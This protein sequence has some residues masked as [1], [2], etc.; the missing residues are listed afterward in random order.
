MDYGSLQPES[1]LN[2]RIIAKQ[3][4][5]LTGRVIRPISML[6]SRD[7]DIKKLDHQPAEI[8]EPTVKA[9]AQEGIYNILVLPLFFGPSEALTG[10]LPECVAQL[11]KKHSRL[12]VHIGRCLVQTN[13]HADNSIAKILTNGINRVINKNGLKFP[14]VILVDHGTP[15][16]KVNEVRTFLTRQLESLLKGKIR[17]LAAAS[18]ERRKGNEYSFNDPLLMHQLREKIFNR[19]GVIISLLF[20]SP[21][22]HAGIGGDIARLCLEAEKR[23]PK[24]CTYISDTIGADQSLVILLKKR[25]EME[26]LAFKKR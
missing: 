23:E 2:L 15:E 21:G 9:L 5:K 24:L 1:T 12:Q 13:N 18:M 26:L 25:L 14:A 11:K 8:F 3:L 4:S 10:Y 20:F 7:V 19:D 22:R 6:H 16:I 17:A